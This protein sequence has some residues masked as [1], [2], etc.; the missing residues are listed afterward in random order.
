MPR[1]RDGRATASGTEPRVLAVTNFYPFPECPYRGVFV[2]NQIESVRALGVPIEVFVIRSDRGRSAYLRAPFAIAALLRTNRFD[3]IH[4]QHTYAF[5]VVWAL[6]RVLRLDVPIALTFRESEFLRPDGF[7]MDKRGIW[8][9]LITSP[10]L[11]RAAVMR[12][13][14]LIAVWS[15]LLGPLGYAGPYEELPSGVDLAK[16]RPIPRHE[17]RRELG[18]PEAERI[19]FFPADQRR[20][21]EKGAD[22]LEAAV[23]LLTARGR[24]LRVEYAE[25]LPHERMPFYMAGADVVVHPT[26]FDASPNVIKEAMAVGTPVVTTV[27]GD[28][29]RVSA[30]VPGVFWVEPD[31]A[32]IAAK[33]E[34]A[35][36]SPRSSAGRDRL[37]AL[38]LSEELVAE[39][40][41][42]L[43]RSW[44]RA[45]R[46][47]SRDGSR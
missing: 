21:R 41:A 26:R 18:W 2:R 14:H 34:L 44:A 31:P 39:R 28:V 47:G 46:D 25:D 38:G 40:L 20:R 43:Y 6:R 33:I 16:F 1:G 19:L 42:A 23:T 27:V 3:L 10:R 24:V 30:E 37:I 9:H 22:L 4:A 36:N 7:R 12:A 5:L 45:P 11:K 8:A 15:G 17:A 13:D 29:S 32:D 35:L